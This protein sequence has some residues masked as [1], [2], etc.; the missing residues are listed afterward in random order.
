MKLIREKNNFKKRNVKNL[1]KILNKYKMQ[2]R[3]SHYLIKNKVS[4]SWTIIKYLPVLPPNIR[5]IINLKDKNII[6]SEI[7]YNYINII[8]INSKIKKLR[9]LLIPEKFIKNEKKK[10]Q[11]KIDELINQNQKT[12][13]F[14]KKKT[15]WLEFKRNSKLLNTNNFTFRQEENYFLKSTQT[16]ICK[17]IS[18]KKGLLRENIL[19]KRVDYSARSVITVEPKLKLNQCGLPEEIYKH[20]KTKN[21]EIINQKQNMI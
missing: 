18:G 15:M 14:Y 7:N 2:L 20:L 21:V 1:K 12:K 4:L 19:G 10:I 9:K 13:K 11:V 17:N 5:P 6:I 8:N 3:I 16:S